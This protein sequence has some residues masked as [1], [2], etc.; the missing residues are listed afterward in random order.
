[1]RSA[2][3]TLAIV[4]MTTTIAACS[5]QEL[6]ATTP[7]MTVDVLPVHATTATVPLLNDLLAAYLE[8]PPPADP[9]TA[10]YQ[11]RLDQVYRGD[12]A[13]FI[14]N[15]L[16]VDSPL[17]AA[18]IGQDG[19]AILISASA[20]V[21]NLTLDQLRAIYQ[22]RITS[23]QEVGGAALPITVFSREDGSGTRAEFER[24]VLGHR[25]VTRNARLA[26][27]SDL[28]VRSVAGQSGAIGYVSLGFGAVE[29]VTVA[30]V[31]G[32]AASAE[33]VALG[34]YP[35]RSTLY[36]A[37]LREPE[38]AVRAFIGWIQSPPGQQAVSRRYVALIGER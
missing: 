5:S 13:Y 19:L 14:T 31:E 27:S 33:N 9:V 11:T 16:P 24:M 7:A 23:W 28:M 10:N 30:A 15:H 8:T 6:P 26:A 25:T 17:W 21:D 3:Y 12:V 29:G 2:R 4:A 20:E 37:G 18:P 36:I 35:L 32:V 22:G 34:L 38:G 1:M